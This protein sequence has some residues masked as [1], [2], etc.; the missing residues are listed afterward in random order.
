MYVS[1]SDCVPYG[2]QDID[3]IARGSDITELSYSRQHLHLFVRDVVNAPELFVVSELVPRGC[4][5]VWRLRIQKRLSARVSQEKQLA[6]VE[7]QNLCQPGYDLVR[8]MTLARL[9]V[10]HI[11]SG[12]LDSARDLFLGEVEMPSAFPNY[13]T[14]R[15]FLNPS[16]CARFPLPK[17]MMTLPQAS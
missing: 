11:G 12:G 16:H 10:S 15:A 7:T 17:N 2:V 4:P 9:Q 5:T 1:A 3:E 14:E 6:R 8:R 13:M